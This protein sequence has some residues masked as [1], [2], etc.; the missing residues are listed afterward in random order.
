MKSSILTLTIILSLSNITMARD[1]S[2]NTARVVSNNRSIRVMNAN[3]SSNSI[4]TTSTT[5]EVEKTK[6]VCEQIFY[7]CMDKK[8]DELVMQN[9]VYF[10]DYN[11]MLTDIYAGMTNPS[12]K[13][14]YKN[15][16]K[17]LY[18]KYYY[19]QTGLD[20]SMGVKK[21]KTKSI[22]Y[23][24]FLK[25]NANDVATKRIATNM[26]LPEVLTIAGIEIEPIGMNSQ[27]LPNVTYKFT[28]L[29]PITS[30]N[31]NVEYC[32]N[33]KTNQDLD[34]CDKLRKNIADDYKTLPPNTIT[35][36]CQDYETFLMDKRT[37]AEE[38]ARTFII[39]LKTKL[40]NNIEEYN[41]KIEAAK[42][43]NLEK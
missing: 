1:L 4:A 19:N 7:D 8:T 24:N 31:M 5:E 11:D 25:Q 16:I 35:K 3:S 28:T 18:S 34:G 40:T 39:G 12:F 10:D 17:D 30:F 43:L 27:S 29:N 36:N 26:I 42:T 20:S 38:E 21:I 41:A 13:C 9:E 32:M 37:K 2:R 6:E 14:L 33:P 22:E 23:Y 15:D